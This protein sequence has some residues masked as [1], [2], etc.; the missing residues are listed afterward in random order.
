M[1]T[2]F[3]VY[4]DIKGL[5]GTLYGLIPGLKDAMQ[6][7]LIRVYNIY[8]DKTNSGVTE[9]LNEQFNCEYPDYF[10]DN[11]DKEWYELNEYNKFMADGYQR[12][13]VD[14]LNETNASEILDFSVDPEEVYLVGHLKAN[15]SVTISFY[16]KEV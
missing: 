11:S 14:E 5:D 4:F 15:K 16:M 12:L 3:K 6:S 13:V 10:K 8:A 2:T 1:E 7:E 9:F